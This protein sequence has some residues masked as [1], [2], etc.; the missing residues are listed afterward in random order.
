MKVLVTGASG[1]LGGAILA[2]ILAD[3]RHSPLGAIRDK[4]GRM[5]EP[6]K[7][8]VVG[9]ISP[10]L[11]WSSA[12][13]GVDVVI[14]TAARAHVLNEGALDPAREYKM[15]NVAG[16]VNLASQ[17]MVAG[18]QRFIFISSIGV[19]GNKNS[20]PFVE[21]DRPNPAEPYAISKLEAEQEL[22]QLVQGANMQSVI[23]RPPLVYGPGAPGNF[24]RLMSVLWR[25]V[26]LPLGAVHNQRSF[27]GLDNLVDLIVTCIDHP[28]AENQ[29]FLAADREVLSTSDLLRRIGLALGKPAR[30]I[31]VPE[32]VLM[33]GAILLGKRSLALQ[34]LGSLRVDISKAKEVLGW[35]PPVSLDEGIRRTA[36]VWVR[37]HGC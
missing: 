30:L 35:R 2:R 20:A 18:V 25:G 23:I 14:H 13:E 37:E 7:A 36:D 21:N 29:I 27:V 5:P 24:N 8:F 12:L 31:P 32:P 19:N 11:D 1:F 16:M 26:P 17:A 15:V 34:L 6:V 22:V 9:S 28:K 4:R 10:D 33:M 3:A